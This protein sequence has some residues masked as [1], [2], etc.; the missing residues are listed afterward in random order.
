MKLSVF[1][2]WSE[3]VMKGVLSEELISKLIELTDIIS[4]DS[5]KV[6][7]NNALAGEIENEWG[8]DVSLLTN[9]KFQPFL[10]E[11]IKEY[12]RLVKIQRTPKGTHLECSFEAFTKNESFFEEN[13]W[14]IETAWFNNQKDNEYNPCHNH[15]GIL[16]GVLYLK[17]PEYLPPRKQQYTDGAITFI[18]NTSPN[19][20]L[21]TSPQFSVLPKVGDIFLFPSTLR[22]QVYPFRTE[23]EQGIRRS[24]SFNI[25]SF[26]IT[27][28]VK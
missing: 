8:I 25:T 12:I 17:I 6:S 22:H 14:S 15:D 26:G 11:L 3:F 13:N 9:V 20:G 4:Q 23:N 16:S 24:M 18:G 2:P 21:F 28:F 10:F 1:Q 19:D 5:Q 7:Y 27:G